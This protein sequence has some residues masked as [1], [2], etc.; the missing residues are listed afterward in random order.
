VY[1]GAPSVAEFCYSSVFICAPSVANL[2]LSDMTDIILPI[3]AQDGDDFGKIIGGVVVVLFWI[4]SAIAGAIGKRRQDKS[5]RQNPNRQA[6]LERELRERQARLREMQGLPPL[7]PPP[8]QPL[9]GSYPSRSIP[10]QMPPPA[11]Q[12][13][14]RPQPAPVSL[15]LPRQVP[16]RPA[17]QPKPA[18]QVRRPRDVVSAPALQERPAAR[19][20]P[21][22]PVLA[23]ASPG[24]GVAR[25]LRAALHPT[26]LRRQILL[27]EIL[28]PPVA[29]RDTSQRP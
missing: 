11:P 29:L 5:R 9:P 16:P 4:I 27:M 24:S 20:T 21:A 25:D 12:A 3:L 15:P 23:A 22:Q 1:I 7:P 17:K 2:L 13:P 10:Q 26:A 8:P 18:K 28:L 19:A 6:D 14:S